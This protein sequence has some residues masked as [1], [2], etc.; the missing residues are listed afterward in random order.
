M[1][2]INFPETPFVLFIDVGLSWNAP[3]TVEFL[4]Q[5]SNGFAIGVEP[6]PN[7]CKRVRNLN[8]GDRFHLI[9][10]GVAN[11]K[12]STMPFNIIAET[13]PQGDITDQ[14]T[15]SFL[16]PTQHF[17]EQGY[18]VLETVEVPVITLKTILDEVPWDRVI[19]GC[20]RLKSDTQ[21]FE[22]EVIASLGDYTERLAQLQIESFTANQYEDS[23]QHDKVISLLEPY[24]EQ[25]HNDGWNAWFS[26][27]K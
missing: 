22:D 7:A 12:E 18:S 10:A 25:T 13:G 4:N 6:N 19:E 2:P 20:F 3:T 16:N 14:G 8:L 24:M 1:T 27:K 26:K 5:V 9:E 17:R 21:G 15:S 11:S 23:S